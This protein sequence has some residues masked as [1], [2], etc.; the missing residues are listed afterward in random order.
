M[1][2]QLP[3]TV[4]RHAATIGSPNSVARDLKLGPSFSCCAAAFARVLQR[5]VSQLSPASPLPSVP[6]RILVRGVSWLSSSSPCRRSWAGEGGDSG[7]EVEHA[8]NR[9]GQATAQHSGG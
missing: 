1:S 8:T 3:S 7:E 6:A 2:A 4:D 5:V 9:R